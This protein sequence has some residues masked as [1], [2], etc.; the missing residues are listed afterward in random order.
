[1]ATLPLSQ[2][3]YQAIKHKIVSLELPPGAVI[4]EN[5]LREEL[6]LGRTPIREALKRLAL[7]KLVI[8]VP[9]RG[10]FVTDIGITDL[11]RL[12]EVR[13][14]L[15]GLAARLAAERGRPYH[16]QQM[17]AALNRVPD[18][19]EADNETLIAIDEACHHIMY[20]AAD[21]E[22]LE[23]T[24]TTMYALSLRLWH[25]SLSNLGRMH[26]TILEHRDILQ[27]LRAG[28]PEEAAEL[29]ETH[30]RSFQ[31]EIQAVMLGA[32]P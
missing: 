31:E 12:F 14:K 24:L 8:I 28:D 17:E 25:F 3:A 21:N 10:M 22:F 1:M 27:A 2:Q 7:E 32:S 5:A 26:S 29:V 20:Q 30:I 16:W 13:V 6:Q 15:E 19:N 11:R 9:R 4:D 23:D 18:T